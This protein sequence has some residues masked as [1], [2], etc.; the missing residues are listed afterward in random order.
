MGKGFGR[1]LPAVGHKIR[2]KTILSAWS[3]HNATVDMSRFSRA[4]QIIYVSSGTAALAVALGACKK[5]SKR[6][7]DLISR[8]IG[9]SFLRSPLK[10]VS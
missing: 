6:R 1:C 4:G 7:H 8:R 9:R 10:V 2:A 3:G 5:K